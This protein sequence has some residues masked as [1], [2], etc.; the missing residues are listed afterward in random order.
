MSS[1]E[2]LSIP[3]QL[4]SE[5]LEYTIAL[6]DR[7][8]LENLFLTPGSVVT[9]FAAFDHFNAVE[10]R[11][12]EQLSPV[13]HDSD[14]PAIT[15]EPTIA[16]NRISEA[17]RPDGFNGRISNGFVVILPFSTSRAALY[18]TRVASEVQSGK[19]SDTREGL[20]AIYCAD[21]ALARGG[22]AKM[23]RSSVYYHRYD[24]PKTSYYQQMGA[25]GLRRLIESADE[26]QKHINLNISASVARTARSTGH[27]VRHPARG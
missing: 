15:I 19:L 1:T 10:E 6:C 14:T 23:V 25:G 24:K 17:L 16:A 12:C 26:L 4:Q 22:I 20:T 27:A 8:S 9:G 21:L 7:S 2:Q 11:I 13:E 3:P 18:E 5:L